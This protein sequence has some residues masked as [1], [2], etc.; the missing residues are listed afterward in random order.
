MGPSRFV[1]LS[2]LRALTFSEYPGTPLLGDR[3]VESQAKGTNAHD[4]GEP[5]SATGNRHEA[6]LKGLTTGDLAGPGADP[7]VAQP[8]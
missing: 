3:P 2:A 8:L 1:L 4:H 6:T 7:S 5:R